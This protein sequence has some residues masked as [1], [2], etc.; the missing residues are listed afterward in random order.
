MWRAFALA[1]GLL[2]ATVPPATAD[3]APMPLEGVYTLVAGDDD[4]STLVAHMGVTAGDP[5][6]EILFWNPQLHDVYGL[7]PG[8]RLRVPGNGIRPAFP[9]FE[10]DFSKWA[11]IASQTTKFVGSP[12]ERVAN[13]VN[14]ANAINNFF[15]DYR[16]PYVQPRDS[17]SLVWLLGD[18]SLANGYVWGHAIGTYDGALIDI[19]AIGGGI[20][21]LPSTIFPAVMKAGLDVTTRTNHSYYP[22]FWWG[23][24][25]G[26]GWDATVQ[27]PWTDFVWRNLYDYPVRLW[28]RAD[29]A[30]WTLTTEVW[31]PPQLTA[32]ATEISGPFLVRGGRFIPTGDA[33]WVWDSS[34][35]VITQ[36]T[37]LD[38][39]SVARAFWSYYGRD[40]NF[41]ALY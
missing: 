40:P 28:M 18:I 17:L 16:H 39:R 10:T 3:A 12:P 9:A 41:G 11:V 6:R 4:P 29:L 5:F 7:A 21:Q 37:I 15:N 22:Y 32:Y 8:M 20:C 2:L 1:C 25:E 33:G 36:Y 19:P 30:N 35:T 31:A 14:G 13:I 26:F 27:P 34:T 24:P 38:G 23:Y